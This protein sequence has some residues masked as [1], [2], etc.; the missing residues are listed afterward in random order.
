MT[1]VI[2]GQLPGDVIVVIE[3]AQPDIIIPAQL[4]AAYKLTTTGKTPI[5][6]N[7][8]VLPSRPYGDL[9]FNRALV[10]DA[11]GVV[12]EYDGV[13]IEINPSG[14]VYAVLNE[15]GDVDGLGVVSYLARVV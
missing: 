14:A 10:Y 13:T 7:R 12:T 2:V 4:G 8:M 11:G 9:L 5:T 1:D 6:D 3:H 15:T